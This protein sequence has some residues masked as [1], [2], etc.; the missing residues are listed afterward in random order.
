MT[1]TPRLTARAL[2]RAT[3]A[4]QHLLA[5]AGLDAGEAV[6]HLVGLQTQ[7]PPNQYTA[8]FSRLTGFDPEDFSR[9]FAAREFVRLSLMRCTLHTVTAADALALRP[10]FDVPHARVLRSAF[11]GELAGADPEAVAARARVVLEDGPPMEARELGALLREEWPQ[12]T[13]RA[14]AM[15]ARQLLPLVQVP[16][17]GLWQ[18]GGEARLTTAEQWLGE[19]AAVR[20]PDVSRPDLVRRY[21]AAFGPA[22]VKDVQKWSGLTR[23]RSVV[24]GLRDELVVFRD[25]TTGA[26]LFDLPDAPRPDADALAPARFLPEFDNVFIGHDDRSRIIPDPG[27]HALAWNGNV[28]RPVFLSDGV[29]KGTWSLDRS[30]GHATLELRPFADLT[31]G[32]RTAL[33][34]EGEALLAFHA[35]GDAQAVR[36]SPWP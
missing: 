32:E 23:L 28:A 24:D 22:S 13:P 16:P 36:W 12:A 17:R 11:R 29:L 33:A 15:A 5:R 31:A 18:R 2:G 6:R 1:T 20:V 14:L 3:L 25:D 21:L 34:E 35:P 7:V 10:L 19:T 26:E 27:R 30:R 9:R 8:L 4:R